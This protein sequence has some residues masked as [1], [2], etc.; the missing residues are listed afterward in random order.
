MFSISE[1]R[2][3]N[4]HRFYRT[5]LLKHSTQCSI[6]FKVLKRFHCLFMKLHN[7]HATKLSNTISYNAYE[8][9]RTCV[10]VYPWL[11]PYAITTIRILS[12]VVNLSMHV[13]TE[14]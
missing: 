8:G 11:Q 4:A 14:R 2:A 5:R 12:Q 7:F 13:N 6:F 9:Q 3:V 1:S 10:D